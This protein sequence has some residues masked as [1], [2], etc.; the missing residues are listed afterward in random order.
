MK[1]NE[2]ISESL[3]NKEYLIPGKVS[4]QVSDALP[5]MVAFKQLRNT[6]PYVQYRM[7]VAFAAAAASKDPNRNHVFDQESA[8]AENMMAVA[9]TDA[10]MEIITMAAKLLNV[11][12]TSLTHGKSK[13]T[14]DVH[15]SSPV[16][17]RK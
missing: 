10:D 13:E 11:N 17:S 6:D 1:I 3:E 9:Y 5:D 16:P 7:G 8:Y 2:I 14:S 4:Q 15:V 12:I